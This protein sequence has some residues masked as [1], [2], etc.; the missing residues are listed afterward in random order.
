MTYLK[1]SPA[2]TLT[3]FVDGVGLLGPGLVSWAQGREQFKGSAPYQPVRCVLPAPMALPQAER[4][5]AGA[6]V[7]VALGV[8]EEAIAASGLEAA[9]LISVFSSSSGDAVNCHEICSALASS[10]RLISPTRFH[11]SVHNAASGYWSISSSSMASS[12]VL[13]AR[14]AS[15]AAG[16][17]EAMTLVATEQIPV[18]LVAYDTDYPEPLHSTRPIPDTFGLA[19]VLAPCRSERSQAQWTLEPGDCLTALPADR[20]AD[21]A[22]EKM[23]TDIPAARCLPLLW[24]TARQRSSRVVLDYLEGLQLT[25]QVAP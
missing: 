24:S 8:S 25:L 18:L 10:D 19:L 14:D 15:F 11:N 17:L 6:V 22:L 7:K 5:R 16:L 9:S 23:R 21:A 12:S 2:Q 1:S 3:A 20:L 13:C 4:R